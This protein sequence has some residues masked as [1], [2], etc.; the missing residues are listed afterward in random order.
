MKALPPLEWNPFCHRHFP[1]V[2]WKILRLDIGGQFN[3][4]VNS[5]RRLSSE[6]LLILY[7]ESLNTPTGS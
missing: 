4:T 5:K 6:V 7:T 1:N 2:T 3:S